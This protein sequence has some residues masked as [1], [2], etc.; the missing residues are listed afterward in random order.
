METIFIVEPLK[1]FATVDDVIKLW[2]ELQ[3]EEKTKVEALLPVV[4]DILREEGKK[5][6]KDLDLMISDSPSYGNVVKL[7]LI[8]ILARNLNSQQSSFDTSGLSQFSQSALGYS[9]SGTFLNGGGGLFIKNSELSRL[10]LKRQRMGV[11]ELYGDYNQGDP[12]NPIYED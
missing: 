1:P 6:G 9:V 5:A 8:D 3:P 4:S 11:I 2:R 10:G 12:N 7:V